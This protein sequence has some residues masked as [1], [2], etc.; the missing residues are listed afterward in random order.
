MTPEQDRVTKTNARYC[1]AYRSLMFRLSIFAI[2]TLSVGIIAPLSAQVKNGGEQTSQSRAVGPLTSADRSRAPQVF[3][4]E[5][6]AV[7]FSVEPIASGNDLLEATE[8]TVR[9]KI[10][11]TL[12][13]K[14]LTNLRPAAWIDLRKDVRVPEAKECREK[15]Q[16]LLQAN[17]TSKADLDL[18]S[19]F[20]LALNHEPN[21]SVIDPFSS[22]GTTRLYTLVAL[23]SPGEDWVLSRDRKRLY[24][25]MPQVNQVAAVDTA[26]WKVVSNI[27]SGVKP[28]RLALQND[29][30]YLWVGNDSEEALASGVTVIDTAKLQVAA[31]VITGAGHH[32]IGF[33]DDDRYAFISNKQAG[34]LSVVDVRKLARIKDLPI[35]LLPTAVVFSSLSKALYVASEGDGEVVVVDGLR[36]QILARIKA[37][38]GLHSLRFMPG[39]RFG[40]A[41]NR[42]TSHVSIFDVSTNRLVQTVPVGQTPDQITFT[43]DFAYVRSQGSEFVTM[44]KVTDLGREGNELA[45]SRFPS[46]QKAP[47]ESPHSSLADTVIPAPEQGAVLSANS[48]DKMIYFYTEG[49]AAPMGSFQNYRRV[50]RAIL[51]LDKSLRETAP[52]LYTTTVKLPKRGDYDVPLLLDSPRLVNCFQMTVVEN[53]AVPKPK[54]LPIR[55]E[56]VTEQRVLK[57]GEKYQLHFK[58][59]DSATNKPKVDL[60]DLGVLVFLAP[61]IWQQREW[62]KALGDGLYEMSFIPPQPGVYYVFF[63]APSL[64]VQ[65][66]QLPSLQLQAER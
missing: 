15:V 64:G 66:N 40:F 33:N 8:A 1:S 65:F 5:G 32:E 36:H 6:V 27:D 20:I 51:V 61:G 45:L 37:Q 18:N 35:G 14:P 9:F 19:Y 56:P 10:T 54:G 39:G 24:V 16:G 11:E 57:V 34:T 59:I 4:Q 58:V 30:K 29:E 47:R 43:R 2:L 50:P 31:Q 38:P 48:A 42:A 7:E 21:I 52:G 41:V 55:V 22:V 49:M 17:F 53:P 12:G 3:K 63:Q 23:P 28:A 13:G 60:K 62:A 26:T 25:S 46:G 44:I